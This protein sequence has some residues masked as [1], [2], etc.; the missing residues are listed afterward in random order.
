[1]DKLGIG[2]CITDSEQA[3]Q[4]STVNINVVAKLGKIHLGLYNRWN[5]SQEALAHL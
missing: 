5:L 4:S 3:F 2:R 1:M